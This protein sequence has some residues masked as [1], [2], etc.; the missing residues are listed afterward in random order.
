[1]QQIEFTDE[2]K[3]HVETID[4]EHQKLFRMINEII[5]ATELDAEQGRLLIEINLDELIKY[6]VYHFKTEEDLMIEH[7]D[8]NY[9]SHKKA[10]DALKAKAIEYKTRFD[11]KE[12]ILSDLVTFLQDWLISHI[13]G[14]D[15]KYVD[16]FKENNV[17]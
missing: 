12:D 16:L 3:T 7:K 10:H 6:T 4:Y 14:I 1:M 2:Y 17:P 8:P 11:N 13:K 15:M 5:S 9:E